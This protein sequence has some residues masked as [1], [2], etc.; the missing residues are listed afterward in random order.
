MARNEMLVRLVGLV[1]FCVPT[2]V[3]VKM[4]NCVKIK[5]NEKVMRLKSSTLTVGNLAMIVKLDMDQGIYSC[6]EEE[7]EI[8]IPT[9]TGVFNVEDYSKTYVVNGEPKRPTSSRSY[10]ELLSPSNS[11]GIPQSYQS[12]TPL[13]KNLN[14]PPGQMSSSQTLQRPSFTTSTRKVQWK[15][16]LVVVDIVPPSGAISEQFQ[17]HLSLTEDT[18]SVDEV[19][20]MLEQ[21]LGFKVILLDSKHLPVI[22]RETTKGKLSYNYTVR[23]SPTF[24]SF[25][26]ISLYHFISL[27]FISFC[28]VKWN[29][30]YTNQSSLN[31]LTSL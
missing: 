6:C 5:M 12:T 8:I 26:F 31:G 4:A 18:S 30:N 1:H 29:L 7:G 3:A 19:Q 25:P 24:I 11:L 14:P 10:A 28:L 17:V 2:Y 22:S 27:G 20:K 23:A 13:R 9:E 16:S 15:K 21:Q